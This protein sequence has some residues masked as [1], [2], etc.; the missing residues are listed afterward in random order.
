MSEVA[1]HDDIYD[2]EKVNDLQDTITRNTKV[3]VTDISHRTWTDKPPSPLNLAT[4]QKRIGSIYGI[5]ASSV[6]DNIQWLYNAGY[7]TYPRTSNQQYDEDFD[8]ASKILALGMQ[9]SI[10]VPDFGGVYEPTKGKKFDP[11][12]PPITP[13]T[14]VPDLEELETHKRLT[15]I[16]ICRHFVATLMDP[17][18]KEGYTYTLSKGEFD[19]KTDTRH[20]V[21]MGYLSHYPYGTTY[22]DNHLDWKEGDVLLVNTIDIEKKET[23]PPKR[24]TSSSLIDRMEKK[25]LGTSATRGGMI[26]KLEKRKY[27]HGNSGIETTR[28]GDNVIESLESFA[29]LITD[30]E[31][32]AELQED[33]DALRMGM[34][35][36]EDVIMDTRDWVADA[37]IEIKKNEK[38]IGRSMIIS[39]CPNCSGEMIYDNIWK[40][41]DCELSK[42]K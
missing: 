41:Q 21:E 7:T 36:V 38:D 11:A 14:I 10:D 2:K 16:Y 19:F 28:L 34:V 22:D 5:S 9:S 6:L 3:T 39:E 29:P 4:A 32:T 15:Y 42:Q 13:T 1:V 40:C 25:N 35:D 17:S 18:V 30:S 20:M 37:C 26:D 8:F 23:N 33:L 27:T 31:F 12:H 24:Y